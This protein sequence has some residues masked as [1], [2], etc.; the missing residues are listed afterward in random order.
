VVGTAHALGPLVLRQGYDLVVGSAWAGI[1]IDLSIAL[2]RI[3][4]GPHIASSGRYILGGAGLKGGAQAL[5][6][7]VL[8]LRL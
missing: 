4:V 8:S 5:A 6:P 2:N 3:P 7:W 1:G